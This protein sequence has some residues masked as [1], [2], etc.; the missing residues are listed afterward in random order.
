MIMNRASHHTR[1]LFED[2][3]KVASRM[4]R[5]P[6]IALFLDFD[7]TLARLQPRPEQVSLDGPVRHAL[8][9]L[10]RNPRFRVWIIS[11]RRRADICSLV[12]VRGIRYLGLHGWEGRPGSPLAGETHRWLACLAA[13]FEALLAP[14]PGVWVEDKEHALAIHYRNAADDDARVAKA[15]L[16]RVLAP[17]AQ[18]FH[19]E[20]GKRVWEIL[21]WELEDKG[22]AVRRELG[23]FAGRALPIYVGDDQVDESAFAVLSA[24]VTVR[25]GYTVSSKAQYR[26]AGVA[27]VRAF[28]HRLTT[29]FA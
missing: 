8:A 5:A 18:Q 17:F 3:T 19:I 28:L 26:L 15:V 20:S 6:V 25:V 16:E 23:F 7:G 22:A 27:Q 2:W 29:E 13:W 9:T 14:V 4:R 24:G 21:P 11:G 10:A 12:R 1:H